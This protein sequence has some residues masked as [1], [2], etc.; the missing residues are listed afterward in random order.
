MTNLVAVY[1][2]K[3]RKK[4]CSLDIWLEIESIFLVVLKFSVSE[5]S[6]IISVMVKETSNFF[7]WTKVDVFRDSTLWSG[8]CKPQYQIP[9]FKFQKYEECCF[10]CL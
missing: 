5:E 9:T 7:Q 3:K 1:D 4:K 2:S 10:Q 6:Q 8:T